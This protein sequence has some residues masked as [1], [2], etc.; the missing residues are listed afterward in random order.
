ML[1]FGV[2]IPATVPQGSEIPEGLMNNPVYT[3]QCWTKSSYSL[4]SHMYQNQDN[5][6]FLKEYSRQFNTRTL[7]IPRISTKSSSF[8]PHRRSAA[9]VMQ[10]AKLI[11]K[12]HELYCFINLNPNE[13][14]VLRRCNSNVAVGEAAD[15]AHHDRQTLITVWDTSQGLLHKTIHAV[16]FLFPLITRS[17]LSIDKYFLKKVFV[18]EVS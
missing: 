1:P 10:T 9:T 13:T 2:T 17:T 5:F 3:T 14:N 12:L 8:D 15:G 11:N 18:P 4:V 7:P 6:F 16:F